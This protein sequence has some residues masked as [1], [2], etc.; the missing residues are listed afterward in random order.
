MIAFATGRLGVSEFGEY[1]KNL[2]LSKHPKL[3]AA[4][5]KVLGGV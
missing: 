3:P 5:A 1:L 2:K 4:K